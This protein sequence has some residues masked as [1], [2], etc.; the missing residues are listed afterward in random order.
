MNMDLS[1]FVHV[2]TNVPPDSRASTILGSKM[3]KISGNDEWEFADEL[4]YRRLLSD[5]WVADGDDYVVSDSAPFVLQFAFGTAPG[6]GAAVSW[7][8]YPMNAGEASSMTSGLSLDPSEDAEF[9]Y[10]FRFD[11]ESYTSD[12]DKFYSGPSENGWRVTTTLPTGNFTARI[13][14]P[15]FLNQEVTSTMP[16]IGYG[17]VSFDIVRGDADMSQEIDSVDIDMVIEA[18]GLTSADAGFLEP[19]SN[20]LPA[21][22]ADVDES[23]EIDA[24]DIDIVVGNFGL[25]GDW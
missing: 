2:K 7:A 18:F 22:L 16:S 14:Y 25:T 9:R 21:L 24:T 4:Q 17:T 19:L 15:T 13:S 11:L 12:T 6:E 5:D 8:S 23:G 1:H 10:P 3:M 20:D